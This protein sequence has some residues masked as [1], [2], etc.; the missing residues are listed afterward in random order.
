MNLE[1]KLTEIFYFTLVN[2]TKRN[3]NHIVFNGTAAHGFNLA[4]AMVSN[5]QRQI[6]RY[7]VLFCLDSFASFSYQ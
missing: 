6:Q 4:L 2:K 5:A 3:F 7:E 1:T